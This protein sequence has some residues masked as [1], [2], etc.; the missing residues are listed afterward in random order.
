RKVRWYFPERPHEEAPRLVVVID[1]VGCALELAFHDRFSRQ[2]AR[3]S[4]GRG[5]WG[6]R[7]GGQRTSLVWGR[8][9]LRPYSRTRRRFARRPAGCCASDRA[10]ATFVRRGRRPAAAGSTPVR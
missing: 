10:W 4:A 6:R 9:M 5:G 1:E 2:R 3:G 8:S 7:G